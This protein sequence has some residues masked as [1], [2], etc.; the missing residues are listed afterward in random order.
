[1]RLAGQ[2][3]G[4][5]SLALLSGC[6]T[7]FAPKPLPPDHPASVQGEEAPRQ[8]IKRLIATDQL[9][10]TTKDQLVRKEAPNPSFQ[11]GAM[12]HDM[13]NMPGMDM[14]K[15]AAG[16][17][18]AQAATMPAMDA[19]QMQGRAPSPSAS[20]AENKTG[21]SANSSPEATLYT[22][23][24]HPEVQQPEPGNCPKCG[25]TLV[26]KEPATR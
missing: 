21:K 14:S 12:T 24:M 3:T 9:T 1:M 18:S 4:I 8:G 13:S 25:M 23:V 11:S 22:C 19:S 15:P 20:P 10:R 2:V 6:A 17:P 16:T 5:A 7:N 26:K